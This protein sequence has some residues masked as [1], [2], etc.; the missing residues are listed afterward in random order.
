MKKIY[1]LL[2]TILVSSSVVAQISVFDVA[3]GG[4][5]PAGW[6]SSNVA[7]SNDIDRGSYYLVEAGD[8]S[9]EIVTAIYD[10]SA[11][12]SAE[13]TLD[14]ASFGSG[15]HNEAQI[16]ISFD[17]GATY[18]QTEVST[19][20]T[21]SSYIDGGTFT[22]NMVS[23]QVQIRISNTGVS[24]RG[25]R[26]RNL[27]LT[28]N[29][30]DP[31][32]EITSPS[33]N[34]N[35]FSGTTSI[36]VEF[37]T[38]N[39]PMN[40]TVNITVI[41]NGGAPVT[42]MDVMSPFTISPV[43]DGDTFDVTVDIMD[44][45]SSV[46]SDNVSFFVEFPCDLNI[47]AI[48]TTCDGETTGTDLYDVTIEFTGGGTTQYTIDT[49]GNGTVGGNSPTMMES[50]VI[51][52]TGVTE[53][54]DFTVTFTG[55]PGNSSCDF[56]R[57]ITSPTC[58]PAATC[59]NPGDIFIS[60][61]M[62]NPSA[63]SDGNGEYFEVYNNTASPID[64]IGWV[65][66]DDATTSENHTISSSAVVPAGGYFVFAINGD[67]GANG[68]ITGAYSYD[69]DISLGNSGTDGIIIE[70]SGTVIDEVIWD[71]GF[72][73]ATA[74]ISMELSETFFARLSSTDNDTGSNW[75]LTPE[76]NTYGDGDRGTP[77]TLNAFS[78]SAD[79]F[80]RTTFSLYPNPTRTGEVSITSN[81]A[82]DISVVGYDILGKQVLNQNVVNNKVNVSHLKAGIYVLRIS[83]NG[84]TT[85]KKLIIE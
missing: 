5:F 35:F 13:F 81:S 42:S 85:T 44:G 34:F 60:E 3:G 22:L 37:S 20:T 36:D 39:A 72:P 64:M 30:T 7:G 43:S 53:G 69:G 2:F 54:V 75:G 46:A 33:D 24:G 28:G 47:G 50:G 31:F 18:T 1:F 14:V 17:G 71:T 38:Q 29:S 26:L 45:G 51:T 70:C 67:S 21:G 27:V 4:A 83:Q 23:N 52:I 16:E 76:G 61:V 74:G 80:N 10:L 48:S 11:F 65:I 19:T 84:A 56:T 8:P 15:D 41:T 12:S 58:L 79:S 25:V 55:D 66:K 63:V 82:S 59:P 32:I 77:G 40:S 49:G 68:G 57:S 73:P 9:D 78:L 62:R 6:T